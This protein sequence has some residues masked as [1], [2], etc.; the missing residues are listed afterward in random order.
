MSLRRVSQ[1]RVLL[2]VGQDGEPDGI[3]LEKHLQS[4]RNRASGGV[5]GKG[6]WKSQIEDLAAVHKPVIEIP[7]GSDLFDTVKA[8][9]KGVLKPSQ[10]ATLKIAHMR[11]AE[12]NDDAEAAHALLHIDEVIA[13]S[14]LGFPAGQRS[15]GFHVWTVPGFV[16]GT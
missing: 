10:E 4:M 14:A 13:V 1:T 6:G 3:H 15:R 12:Y 7:D 11:L 2:S 5:G 16:Q 9:V 8:Y